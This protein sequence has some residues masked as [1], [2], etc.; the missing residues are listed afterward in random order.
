MEYTVFCCRLLCA[1]VDN[2]EAL[3]YEWFPGVRD[4]D[5]LNGDELVQPMSLCPLCPS[6]W[7]LQ[8]NIHH[9]LTGLSEAIENFRPNF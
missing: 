1:F 7:L 8:L 3:L 5:I 2:V 6:E 4:V 9:P